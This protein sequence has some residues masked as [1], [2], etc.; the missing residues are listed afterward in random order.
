[1]FR[2]ED[3]MDI[4]VGESQSLLQRNLSHCCNGPKPAPR[5]HTPT[6]H[7]YALAEGGDCQLVRSARIVVSGSATDNASGSTTV[8]EGLGSSNT[9]IVRLHEERKSHE[10]DHKSHANHAVNT[11]HAAQHRACTNKSRQH[12]M[13]GRSA[14][15][16]ARATSEVRLH[17][18]HQLG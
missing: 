2:I 16:G 1:M 6:A 7:A 10:P 5:Q 13:L 14:R 17:T 15:V 11:K 12:S 3:E 18:Q 8:N 4:N 9:V